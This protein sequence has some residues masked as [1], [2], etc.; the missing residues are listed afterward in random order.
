MDENKV[1]ECEDVMKEKVIEFQRQSTELTEN[2]QDLCVLYRQS[3]VTYVLLS[4]A[5]F[6]CSAQGVDRDFAVG[7]FDLAMKTA[8]KDE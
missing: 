1:K 2:I 7:V 6:A 5:G 3:V 4:C 8:Q